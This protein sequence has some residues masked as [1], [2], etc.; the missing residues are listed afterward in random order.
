[1]KIEEI[2]FNELSRE[3]LILL[4][5]NE[6]TDDLKYLYDK[7][8]EL[9]LKEVGNKVY[10]RGLIEISNI[11]SKNCYYC[12]VRKGN[13]NVERFMMCK[14]EI[15]KAAKWAYDHDYASL[16]IQSG[17]RSDPEFV[18]FVTEILEEI[19]AFS[20]G[21]MGITLS[22]G[23]QTEDTYRRWREAGASRFLLRIETSDPELY[24]KLHPADH[25][26]QKRLECLRLLR[27]T[28]YQVG[29]G[30]MIGLPGQTAE[31]LADDIIFFKKYDID[32]IGMGPWLPHHDTPLGQQYPN[33]DMKKQLEMG[34]KMIALVRLF[35]KDVNIAATTALQAIDPYGR[36]R[37]LMAGANVIM[38]VI[39]E[40]DHRE[41]YV[42][43][44]GKPISDES[45]EGF[46]A[47][48]QESIE[49]LGEV[50]GYGEQGNSMHWR[51]R[52][53]A[54]NG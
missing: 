29:T 37:G 13:A 27:K 32:M 20:N 49:S 38:P 6:N 15:I 11:C 50:I 40:N 23:E 46:R 5:Q 54:L 9:K 41:D 39:T 30:V 52:T 1:M 35:L 43:Y 16:A 53:G 24:K 44:D 25:S 28:G 51:K 2:N 47:A 3:E 21:D 8:Y 14:S 22:V 48:L 4:L 19:M 26:Y 34:I 45:A 10:L 31:S 12:G 17:E 42:L 18:E 33:I 36:E 7:A